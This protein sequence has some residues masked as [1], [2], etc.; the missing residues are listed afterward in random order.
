MSSVGTPSSRAD[1]AVYSAERLQKR[2]PNIF[3]PGIF[4][5][6]IYPETHYNHHDIHQAI[7]VQSQWTDMQNYR[8]NVERVSTSASRFHY[9]ALQYTRK[10][11][12]Q[13]LVL[14]ESE[15]VKNPHDD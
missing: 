7:S 1:P 5:F 10:Y 6:D 4:H 15:N 11:S 13:Y 12:I 2:N 3:P 9:L 8:V 14:Q